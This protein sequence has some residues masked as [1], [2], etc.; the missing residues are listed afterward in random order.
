MWT[1][2]LA[3]TFTVAL[4]ATVVTAENQIVEARHQR[5]YVYEAS[6]FED[7][8]PNELLDGF[9]WRNLEF[10][11]QGVNVA[12]ARIMMS[13]SWSPERFLGTDYYPP[14]ANFTVE[15]PED[16]LYTYL[17]EFGSISEQATVWIRTDIPIKFQPGF[18]CQRIWNPLITSRSVTQK[19]TVIFEPSI[20]GGVYIQVRGKSTSEA[21]ITIVPESNSSD[22]HLL[23]ERFWLDEE[24]G[25]VVGVN[26]AGDCEVGAYILSVDI[27][28]E[29]M[30]FPEPIFY[31]PS[32]GI[33]L[34]YGPEPP[35]LTSDFVKVEDDIDGDG[36]AESTITYSG[37]GDI[38]WREN[39]RNENAVQL[40]SYSVI[41]IPLQTTLQLSPNPAVQGE[42]VTI[43][44]FVRDL[45]EN[46]IEEATVV[47]TIGDL[48]AL[49]QLSDQGSG[50]YTGAID[51][52]NYEEG[53]YE[54][55]VTARKEGYVESQTPQ[56]LTINLIPLQISLQL[57]PESIASG[58][59]VELF[60]TVED[61]DGNPVSG[62]E[63][64]A[65]LPPLAGIIQL[66]EQGDGNYKT[67]LS[68][69]GYEEGTFEVV[70]TARKAPGY[71]SAQATGNFSVK[72]P[73]P[74]L[75]YG[76]IAATAVFVVIVILY[77]VKKSS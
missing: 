33:G 20:A 13:T 43:M 61:E 18:S 76:G 6:V 55:V 73:I 38:I 35:P 31:K 4:T 70:V 65:N 60:V 11:P 41:A 64:T 16:D 45:E 8:V 17:W 27:T 21:S 29:N 58:E 49:I 5:T 47:A 2:F 36:L 72:A 46:P 26:W 14:D 44:S 52:A 59:S 51:T 15:G 77:L 24:N 22:P 71:R 30:F 62:A 56:N 68:T 28:V 48:E 66:D 37:T 7:S 1:L 57:T 54:V 12:D 40:P 69:T 34:G 74:W 50:E 63:V 39:V 19:L 23:H 53:I 9:P 10:R 67:I 75:L 32:V 25:R 42:T 3:T